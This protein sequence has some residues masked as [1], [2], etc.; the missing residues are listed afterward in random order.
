MATQET[1]GCFVAPN[2]LSTSGDPNVDLHALQHRIAGTLPLRVQM[3]PS[4]RSKVADL[5]VLIHHCKF[6]HLACGLC[7]RK[8]L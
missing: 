1:L 8:K 3:L 7:R 6:H 5:G 2:L 4:R